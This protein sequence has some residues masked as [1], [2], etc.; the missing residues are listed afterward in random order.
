MWTDIK[1]SPAISKNIKEML[2]QKEVRKSIWI[3]FELGNS[4]FQVFFHFI[5]FKN[6][7]HNV[8]QLFSKS[9]L[10]S[11][12]LANM[13][14]KLLS[15]LGMASLSTCGLWE[16]FRK[17]VHR[18]TGPEKLC[19]PLPNMEPIY[20]GTKGKLTGHGGLDEHSSPL[21]PS[22]WHLQWPGC[23]PVIVQAQTVFF[24]LSLHFILFWNVLH[25]PFSFL[26]VRQELLI[27]LPC[28]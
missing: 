12:T 24:Q 18:E 7:H 28:P 10:L 16:S 13:Q 15:F 20:N 9:F 21:A 4:V 1:L 14:R 22:N 11:H 19:Q 6:I 26:S 3:S 27:Y 23:A 17:Q 2:V 8:V 25:S 5:L